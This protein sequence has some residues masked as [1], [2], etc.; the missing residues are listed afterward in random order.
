MLCIKYVDLLCFDNIDNFNVIYSKFVLRAR[1]N[2]R[3]EKLFYSI[4]SKG[5]MKKCNSPILGFGLAF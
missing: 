5:F 4:G 1:S 2:N 3:D